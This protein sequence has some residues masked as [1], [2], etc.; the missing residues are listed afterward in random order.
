MI[1]D[2]Y[3][4][5]F[6]HIPK[7]AGSSITKV[8]GQIEKAT[9]GAQDHRTIDKLREVMSDD[10]FRNY[11]KF[12]FVRNP[13]ARVASWYKNVLQDPIHRK[14]FGVDAD[15]S[16]HNFLRHH[17]SIWG[18]QSQLHWIRDSDGEIPLD[19]IGRHE[20]LQEHFQI[21]CER[22]GIDPISLPHLVK[23]IDSRP[24]ESLYD[25]ETRD[26]VAD[27][28]A[29]EIE[30]FKY[31]F[32]PSRRVSAP[33]RPKADLQMNLSSSRIESLTDKII[34]KR[35]AWVAQGAIGK[36]HTRYLFEAA[37]SSRSQIAVE[38]GTASGC[39][40][41]ILCHALHEASKAGYVG[42]DFQVGSFDISSQCL[43][44]KSKNVGD[45][46]REQLPSELLAHV[47]F[48]NPATAADMGKH[49]GVNEVG[50]LFIDG[51]HR[52]PWATLDLLAALPYLAPAARVVLHDIQLP[53]IH[54]KFDEW[55]AKYLFDDL[56]IPKEM[57]SGAALPNIGS[58]TIP[59]DK[60]PFEAQLRKILDARPW[61][62]SVNPHYL[63]RL[64]LPPRAS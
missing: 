17:G 2:Q 34:A 24:Y 19:F 50:F 15:C 12:A 64:G 47:H 53:Q 48:H 28:Y 61:Q 56:D 38:I 25:E 7:T 49:F 52:H 58:F 35:P 62:A 10:D 3:R 39:S 18:L 4:C 8:L 31:T 57:P 6:V 46:A 63:R 20:Q 29:E 37:V 44:D 33:I 23:A 1:S 14:N 59:E 11:F 21:V 60:L 9:H 45:A 22:L 43:F 40:A 30:L 36:A 55:G 41:V 5:V 16:L 32:D 27:R 54:P 51:N 13:W 26:L 42:P